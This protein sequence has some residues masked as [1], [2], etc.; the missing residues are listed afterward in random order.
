MTER[1][2]SR[3]AAATPA[4]LQA[5]LRRIFPRAIVHPSAVSGE[6]PTWYVYRDGR[7]RPPET[8]PW[9]D[10]PGLPRVEVTRDGW[11]ANANAMALGLLEIE[12]SERETRHF[13]DFLAPGTLED[14]LALFETV[15]QGHELTATV[16]LRP[17][18]GH[19][20][21]VD[22]RSW[23]DGERL[24]GV[25]RLADDVDPPRTVSI[26][27]PVVTCE[28]VTDA[29]FR[30]YVELALSRMPEP[31]ADGLALRLHRLYP[32]A[33][34]SALDDRWVARRDPADERVTPS[35]WWADSSLPSVRYDAQGLIAAANDAAEDLLGRA[36]VGH[37]WQEFV[38]PGSTEEVAAM[39]AILSEVGR[40]ESRFRMPRADGT[41][42]E[43]DSY[44]EVTNDSFTTVMRPRTPPD[45][46]STTTHR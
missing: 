2:L 9:W 25:L 1:F 45:S 5:R 12:E 26:D 7:W 11:V 32:H 30:G 37:H 21:A 31:T 19:V 20:V 35:E 17:T 39:L 6:L 38:T 40:A 18:S 3:D 16:L 23:R 22:I 8:T 34:V 15:D 14:S 10:A 29:A 28:P 36:M 44:T 41:L 24:I 33:G 13:T 4:A 46:R 27:R 42:I 43:F